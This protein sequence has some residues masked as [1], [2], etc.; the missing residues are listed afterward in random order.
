MYKM[1]YMKKFAEE[2]IVK[3]HDC[4]REIN[5][6]EKLHEESDYY[7]NVLRELM[8]RLGIEEQLAIYIF[9]THNTLLSLLISYEDDI[10]SE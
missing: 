2:D 1:N 8:D 9:M 5:I 4:L 3:L 7:I 10:G 6:P